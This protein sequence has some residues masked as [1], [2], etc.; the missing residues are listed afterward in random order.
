[1][2]FPSHESSMSCSHASR[3]QSAA[4]LSIIHG[5]PGITL[6]VGLGI[7]GMDFRGGEFLRLG[8]GSPGSSEATSAPGGFSAGFSGSYHARPVAWLAGLREWLATRVVLQLV[9][10]G[11]PSKAEPLISTF[12]LLFRP[13]PAISPSPVE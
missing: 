11:S 6:I 12:F 2:L 7:A 8:L 10:K 9:S 4:L 13:G 1:M 5:Q 3:F